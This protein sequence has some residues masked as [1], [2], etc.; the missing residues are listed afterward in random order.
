MLGIPKIR[1]SKGA[2]EAYAVYA[3]LIDWNVQNNVMA[4]CFDTT[5]SNTSTSIGA[6]AI[7]EQKLS[8][9]LLH[10]ACRHH[11]ME[12]LVAGAFQA[13][14]EPATSAPSILLFDRF[15]SFWPKLEHDRSLVFH[16]NK[17]KRE[18]NHFIVSQIFILNIFCLYYHNFRYYIT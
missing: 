4:M 6:C 2:D 5:A 1:S 8:K 14:V 18:G 11:I 16:I 17:R 7:L 15:R 9:K 12:L 13:T 10:F 3:A